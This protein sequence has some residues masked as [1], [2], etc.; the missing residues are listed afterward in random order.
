MNVIPWVAL[1]VAVL[2]NVVTNISLKLAAKA[3]S[4]ASSAQLFGSF[5]RQ[6]WIWIGLCAGIVLLGSYIFAIRY[7]GLG[8]SYAIVTSVTLVLVTISAAFVFQERL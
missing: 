4:S 6:P 5:L 2:A 7:I 8:L 1:C 3:T